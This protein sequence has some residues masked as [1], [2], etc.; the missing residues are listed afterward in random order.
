N[1]VFA[2]GKEHTATSGWLEFTCAATTNEADENGQL[3]DIVCTKV[4]DAGRIVA[5]TANGQ[6]TSTFDEADVTGLTISSVSNSGGKAVFNVASGA[7]TYVAGM[8][9]KVNGTTNYDAPNEWHKITGITGNAITTDTTYIANDTGTAQ[10]GTPSTGL[11]NFV[12]QRSTIL[13]GC[14]LTDSDGTRNSSSGMALTFESRT[15]NDDDESCIFSLG[16]SWMEY[17][18]STSGDG[19]AA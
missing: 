8:K 10:V 5:I 6:F 2:E 13:S 1:V 15:V 18:I 19:N 9:L 3:G 12:A 11:A 17:E 4:Y 14:L 16:S 7:P